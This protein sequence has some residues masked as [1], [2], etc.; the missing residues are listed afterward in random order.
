MWGGVFILGLQADTLFR[1]RTG[2]GDEL[3]ILDT[4]RGSQVFLVY[5]G[6]AGHHHV[7]RVVLS[8]FGG[9]ADP[10]LAVGLSHGAGEG[11]DRVNNVVNDRA[12]DRVSGELQ[13]H[14]ETGGGRRGGQ[15]PQRRS[16]AGERTSSSLERIFLKYGTLDGVK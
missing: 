1:G 16:R 6:A 3:L 2:E 12:N 8:L 13:V 14:K 7:E 5:P 15:T 9:G 11:H 4:V 10:R